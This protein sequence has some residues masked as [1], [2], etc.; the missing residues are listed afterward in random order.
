MKR[1]I[2]EKEKM[3]FVYMLDV[4]NRGNKSS[5]YGH[6]RIF[7]TGETDN[8]KVRLAQHIRG[9]NSKFLNNKFR[10]ARKR[11]VFVKQIYGTEYDAMKEETRIKNKNVEQK[12][13]LIE[14][15]NDLVSYVPFKCV[16]L[17]KHNSEGEYVISL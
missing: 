4:D 7:Y 14:K 1:K 2:D 11:L 10:D 8:L 9:I 15:E 13:Q 12:K 17:K 3:R 5:F 6:K 16:I